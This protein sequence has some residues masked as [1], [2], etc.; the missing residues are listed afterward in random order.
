[1]IENF[2]TEKNLKAKMPSSIEKSCL[3]SRYLRKMVELK[4]NKKK[5]ELEELKKEVLEKFRSR[6]EFAFFCNETE[7]V[8]YRLF[9]SKAPVKNESIYTKKLKTEEKEEMRKHSISKFNANIFPTA[10]FGHYYYLRCPISQL[11]A[12][13]LNSHRKVSRTTIYQNLDKNVKP[14]KKTPHLQCYCKECSNLESKG[15]ALFHEHIPGTSGNARHSVEQTWCQYTSHQYGYR[16]RDIF[17][18]GIRQFPKMNCVNRKCNKCGIEMLRQRINIAVSRIHNLSESNDQLDI[19]FGK[20]IEWEEW[21]YVNKKLES[22]MRRSTLRNLLDKYL[23]HLHSMSLHRFHDMWMSH[24]FNLLINHIIKGMVVFINDFAQNILLRFQKEPASVHWIHKQ[25]TLHPSV[26]YFM[27]PGCERVVIKE[28]IF[29]I[30]SSL[31][32][33]WKTVDHFM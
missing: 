23:T 21:G 18:T 29:H 15:R 5:L 8:I 19:K 13:W 17:N 25:V 3:A 11:H 10:R 33:D 16:K 27:C 30:T 1:M 26:A 31:T 24:Q 4:K 2:V 7:R 32:H 20:V 12:D 28:E 14:M 9:Q 6:R 22:I